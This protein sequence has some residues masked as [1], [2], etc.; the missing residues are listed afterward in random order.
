MKL[1]LCWKLETCILNMSEI[2]KMEKR[3]CDLQQTYMR[4]YVA[5]RAE[6]ND[7]VG[8]RN[9]RGR[10]LQLDIRRPSQKLKRKHV[11]KLKFQFLSMS[12]RMPISDSIILLIVIGNILPHS[13]WHCSSKH[14]PLGPNFHFDT[15]IQ[16]LLFYNLLFYHTRVI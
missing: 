14:D 7:I 13:I 8:D 12:M 16:V 10:K 5:F 15:V 2:L 11:I 1:H 6:N 9:L 3:Q 4:I